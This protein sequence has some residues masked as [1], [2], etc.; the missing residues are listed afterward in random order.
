MIMNK[1][2]TLSSFSAH[3]R[4]DWIFKISVLRGN[5]LVVAIHHINNEKL[6]I[7]GYNGEDGALDFMN[8]LVSGKEPE[9]E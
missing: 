7:R 9:N 1:T 5:V 3:R 6:Y 8:Q 4:G 2:Y